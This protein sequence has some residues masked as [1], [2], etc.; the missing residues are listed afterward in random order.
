MREH[1]PDLT[2]IDVEHR[3][4]P[5]G[6]RNLGIP[7]SSGAV[8][9]YLPADG[10]AEPGWVSARLQAHARGH[11]AV[12]AAM[13]TAPP[14]GPVAWGLHFDMY[15]H[16]LVGRPAGPLPIGDP[17]AHGL[18]FDRALLTRTGPFDDTMRI[19]EDTDMARRVTDAGVVIWFE[20]A[21]V[22]AHHGPRGLLDLL[23]DAVPAQRSVRPGRRRC[24]RVRWID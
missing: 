11:A 12:A 9:A 4:L 21:I 15:C 16:R 2:V 20:P 14:Q 7:A 10:I 5:G 17:A 18:S 6:A 22:T 19:D 1:F 23:R 13:T 3:L 24:P 8:V